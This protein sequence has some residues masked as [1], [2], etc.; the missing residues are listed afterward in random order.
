MCEHTTLS[1]VLSGIEATRRAVGDEHAAF[2]TLR[3]RLTDLT[4]FEPAANRPTPPGER[5]RISTRRI[6]TA[7][8]ETIMS[9]PHYLAWY[10]HTYVRNVTETL[11][12]TLATTLVESSDVGAPILDELDTAVAEQITRR[13]AM[14]DAIDRERANVQTIADWLAEGREL[15]DHDESA[16]TGQ[17]GA[18]EPSAWDRLARVSRKYKRATDRRHQHLRRRRSRKWDGPGE[19]C[20]AFLYREYD[21][22]YPVLDAIAERRRELQH[23]H[24]KRQT[25]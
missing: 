8:R 23:R 24:S 9:V 2:E 17:S 12:P 3:S 18:T 25:S 14:I 11:G 13:D 19:S 21:G 5:R 1:T 22:Q 10:N 15:L 4:P 7:Y 16:V 6:E 20:R